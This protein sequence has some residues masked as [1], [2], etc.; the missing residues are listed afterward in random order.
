MVNEVGEFDMGDIHQLYAAS[1]ITLPA[2]TYE[3]CYEYFKNTEL[4][5]VKNYNTE[6]DTFKSELVYNSNLI[7]GIKV[8]Y[9][10]TRAV[11]HGDDLPG[12]IGKFDNLMAVHNFDMLF[13]SMWEDIL[14]GRQLGLK[15]VLEYHAILM[16]GLSGKDAGVFRKENYPCDHIKDIVEEKD[17]IKILQDSL[18]DARH[19]VKDSVEDTIV[20]AIEIAISIE[21][22]RPFT[23]GN[24]RMARVMMN[25]V[26]LL[27][28]MPPVVIYG[29]DSDKYFSMI[30]KY[31]RDNNS[32]WVEFIKQCVILTWEK[33]VN[34]GK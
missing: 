3:D 12:Y 15:Q 30:K 29:T 1:G 20:K 21:R 10:V 2:V 23:D 32:E 22:I 14:R 13:D 16:S 26:L 6:L 19:N 4:Y 5:S 11:M 7:S 9:Y 24:G 27:N 18:D 25:Y 17:I 31:S 8:D 33:R 34:G 28:G